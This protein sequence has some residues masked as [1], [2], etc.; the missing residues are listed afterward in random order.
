M[1]LERTPSA[2]QL[3]LEKIDA[4][5]E[6]L[7]RERREILKGE[8]PVVAELRASALLPG[9]KLTRKNRHKLEVMGRVRFVLE[10][11]REAT[12]GLS[13]DQIHKQMIGIEISFDSL[14]SYLSRFKAEGRLQHFPQYGLW[15]LTTQ[16]GDS[17]E[18]N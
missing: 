3:R 14:R 12:H 13:S 6:A 5:I 11:N 8:H 1:T 17:V 7:Q 15:K 2:V 9:E 18:N 10:R 4:K 16:E